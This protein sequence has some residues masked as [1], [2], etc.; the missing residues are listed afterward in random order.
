MVSTVPH[1][2][3][4]EALVD[5]L[6]SMQY[7]APNVLTS[8]AGPIIASHASSTT[9][10]P[11]TH[12]VHTRFEND[13]KMHAFQTHPRVANAKQ[14]MLEYVQGNGFLQRIP[15]VA[16]PATQRQ[17]FRFKRVYPTHWKTCF[18]GQGHGTQEWNGLRFWRCV[19][20]SRF[21]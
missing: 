15:C 8:T 20:T 3:H 13:A 14:D 12:A 9:L 1:Q 16:I 19:L 4:L 17:S 2:E 5:Q 18:G 10:P 21:Y 11:C 6:W 7:M